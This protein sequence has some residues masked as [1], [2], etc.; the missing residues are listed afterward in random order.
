M[1]VVATG[2]L[3]DMEAPD[4]LQ[5]FVVFELDGT[6]IG[7]FSDEHSAQDFIAQTGKEPGPYLAYLEVPYLGDDE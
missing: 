2:E 7:I 6:P 4:G 3:A 1:F 5:M